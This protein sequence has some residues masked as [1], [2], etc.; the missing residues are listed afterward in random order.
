MKITQLTNLSLKFQ[1]LAIFCV[2]L[3]LTI[4]GS[5]V[6]AGAESV[7][8]ADPTPVPPKQSE[9][10]EKLPPDTEAKVER[11]L[12][13]EK[14]TANLSYLN[15]FRSIEDA[16]GK[17]G[18]TVFNAPSGLPGPQMPNPASLPTPPPSNL[19]Q[20]ANPNL[21]VAPVNDDFAERMKSRMAALKRGEIL[22]KSSSYKINE[23]VP[24]GISG[25]AKKGDAIEFYVPR[26]K[27]TF[28]APLGA[29]FADGKLDSVSFEDG[30]INLINADGKKI[31]KSWARRADK[32]P[33]GERN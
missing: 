5:L 12:F 26:N 28:V 27:D 31:F 30:G 6:I 7:L 8:A 23:V 33:L 9:V 21:P 24:T 17:S 11:M 1:L 25:S 22:S 2:T 3:I 13:P 18:Q 29:Q 32:S 15:P 19:P 14:P 10:Y 20:A 16:A 4:F